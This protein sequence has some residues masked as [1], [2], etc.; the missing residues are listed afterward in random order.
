M[1]KVLVLMLV[2]GLAIGIASQPAAAKK[3]KKKIHGAFEAQA[4]PFPNRSGVTGTENP[5]CFAGEE[6]VHKVS[7]PFIAP[8]A[9]T[10]SAEVS[11][12]DGDWDLAIAD[13]TGK[14]LLASLAEQVPPGAPPEEE[15]SMLVTAK[16]NLN[17]VACN[18]LGEPGP[19]EVHWMFAPK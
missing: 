4:L 16:Q 3:K 12:F 9:G 13:E 14:V 1:R 7:E 11:G 6:G 17:I 2:A 5:G 8:A 10:L 19:L 15:V 18:W